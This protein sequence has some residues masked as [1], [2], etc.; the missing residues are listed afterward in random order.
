[1]SGRCDPSSFH[2]G[3]DKKSALA[4]ERKMGHDGQKE[5]PIRNDRAMLTRRGL[6]EFA[7]VAIATAALP[8]FVAF[9]NPAASQDSPALDS[10]AQSISPVMEKL[11]TYMSKAA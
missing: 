10:Q 6:F 3:Q 8:P 11:S 2:S 5:A 1:M 7:G 4:G 9:A